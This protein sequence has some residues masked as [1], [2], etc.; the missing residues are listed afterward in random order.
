MTFVCCSGSISIGGV[1]DIPVWTYGKSAEMKMPSM[2]KLSTAAPASS[3]GAAKAAAILAAQLKAEAEMP[4]AEVVWALVTPGQSLPCTV[5]HRSGAC[6]QLSPCN[7]RGRLAAGLRESLLRSRHCPTSLSLYA[8][9]SA[10]RQR[11]SARK[12]RR[13]KQPRTPRSP[14][15]KAAQPRWRRWVVA[16]ASC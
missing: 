8:L 4:E 3:E 14:P 9:R 5:S 1:V 12:S 13:R 15:P 2:K 10:R 6:E 16:S 11:R 7:M